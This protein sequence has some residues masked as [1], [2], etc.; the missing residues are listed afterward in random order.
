LA[1]VVEHG[2]AV[3]RDVDIFAVGIVAEVEAIDGKRVD[4]LIVTAALRVM[5][6]PMPGLARDTAIHGRPVQERAEQTTLTTWVTLTTPDVRDKRV[7]PTTHPHVG[8]VHK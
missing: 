4:L 7:T 5:L 6:L 1:E 3:L 8:T 2:A